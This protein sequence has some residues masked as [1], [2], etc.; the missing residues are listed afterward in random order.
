M[1]GVM[2]VLLVGGPACGIAG[3]LLG[4]AIKAVRSNHQSATAT[5]IF[6]LSSA[7]GIVL[8]AYVGIIY[9]FNSNILFVYVTALA[10]VFVGCVPTTFLP[11]RG[12]DGWLARLKA[13]LAAA[14]TINLVAIVV[15][16]LLF[17]LLVIL[18]LVN[19]R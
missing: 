12:Y 10:G 11:V 17:S 7:T 1:G 9:Y 4:L 18:A 13:S 19:H 2:G 15:G 3:C 5:F 16:L 14:A 6:L 8:G